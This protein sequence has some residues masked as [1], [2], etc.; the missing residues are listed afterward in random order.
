MPW[1]QR[2]CSAWSTPGYSC[3]SWRP[4]P[5]PWSSIAAPL[6]RKPFRWI[7]GICQM[8]LKIL[9]NKTHTF[10]IHYLITERR[11][12]LLQ[13]LT[14]NPKITCDFW[15]LFGWLVKRNL[16]LDTI[17]KR[18]NMLQW[19]F[20]TKLNHSSVSSLFTMVYL[21][22]GKIKQFYHLQLNGLMRE[23]LYMNSEFTHVRVF[24]HCRWIFF[25]LICVGVAPG[26]VSSEVKYISCD[27]NT[28]NLAYK[29]KMSILR[30]KT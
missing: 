16:L 24:I 13:I 10:T 30:F 27:V 15:S 11:E 8:S 9:K 1:C 26:L 14:E 3:P 23:F 2:G 22:S 6:P 19:M 5:G 21:K 17:N 29:N 7:P 4:P 25:H 20:N 18:K 28:G 12:K